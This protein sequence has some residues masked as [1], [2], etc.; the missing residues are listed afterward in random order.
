MSTGYTVGVRE[1]KVTKFKDFAMQCA[2]AFDATVEMRDYDLNKPIPEEFKPSCY[3]AD[4]L[5]AAKAKLSRLY[6]YTQKESEIKAK[7]EYLELLKNYEDSKRECKIQKARY[8]IMLDKV[9]QWVPP[10]AD[11]E[12][13]KKFMI[14][15]LEESI[16]F[17]CVGPYH[18][19]TLKSGSFW[20][21][22][23][24]KQVEEDILYHTEEN[25]KEIERVIG[26][27]R[28]IRELRQSLQDIK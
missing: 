11:H 6:E 24:I 21:E 13:L 20:R 23:A 16:R 7:A 17:D 27:N 2:R 22:T 19:P 1:G 12:N 3:H 25:E 4:G 14:E 26:R 5:K 8:E 10:T 9:K 18:R 15:Q 28:W